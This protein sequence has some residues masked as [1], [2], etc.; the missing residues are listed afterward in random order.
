VIY[1]LAAKPLRSDFETANVKLPD[2]Y[3]AEWE[4]H[5]KIYRDSVQ[6]I[7]GTGS[8]RDPYVTDFTTY[9]I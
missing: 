5:H 8:K 9:N 4:P 7:P 1:G 2:S 6:K 3:I